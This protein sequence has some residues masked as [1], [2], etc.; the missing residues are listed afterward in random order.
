MKSTHYVVAGLLLIAAIGLTVWLCH[1]KS[2]EAYLAAGNAKAGQKDWAGAVA[3]YTA[4]IKR[5]PH[6]ANAYCAR[7]SAS[8]VGRNGK[9][10]QAL[11]DC[12]QAIKYKTNYA[13]AYCIRGEIK[14]M[15]GDVAG[16]L[17]DF[18]QA[19]QLQPDLSAAYLCRAINDRQQGKLPEALADYT[20]AAKLETNLE[21]RAIDAAW[22]TKVGQLIA[23]AA[24]PA[25][26]AAN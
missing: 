2:A 12:N 1:G 20:T 15:T 23:A 9:P 5:N 26:P 4:A 8:R 7:A 18:N 22:A 11:E 17:A 25:S 3:D 6:F 16:G 13:T 10:S 21:V 19:I 24:K 14:A